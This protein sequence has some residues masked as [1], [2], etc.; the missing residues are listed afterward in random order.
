MLIKKRDE[1]TSQMNNTM[2]NH[3]LSL[4]VNERRLAEEEEKAREA[5]AQG[6]VSENAEYQ[7][8]RDNCARLMLEIASLES[9]LLEYEKYSNSYTPTGRIQV[10][11]TVK[12]HDDSRNSTI[13]IKLYPPG[14]GNAKIGAISVESPVGRAL[15][16]RVAGNRVIAHAPRGDLPYTIEEV[17]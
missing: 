17:L 6:D 12:L 10:G 15:M 13:Y 9:V 1:I 5:K 3:R 2:R 14:L 4:K 11:S 7:I 8:A 16:G